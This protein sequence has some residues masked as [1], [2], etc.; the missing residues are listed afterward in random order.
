MRLEDDE[1]DIPLDSVVIDEAD[2]VNGHSAERIFVE[3]MSRTPE[4][5]TFDDLIVLPGAIN[6][7]VS[8]VDLTTKVARKYIFL[9][10]LIC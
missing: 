6:F 4:G 10:L 8:E 1:E 7:G 3:H 9:N 5:I 2:I